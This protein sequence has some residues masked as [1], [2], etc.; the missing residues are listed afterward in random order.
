MVDGF[1]LVVYERHANQVGERFSC[2]VHVDLE[3][4]EATA[5]LD[6]WRGNK[7]S[8]PNV[9]ARPDEVLHVA[10]FAGPL[11]I[12]SNTSHQD[13]VQLLKETKANGNLAQSPEP[14]I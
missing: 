7:A 2:F 4:L 14:V 13:L 8:L 5:H 6:D 11:R 3:L 10:K 1:E 9:L 12:P